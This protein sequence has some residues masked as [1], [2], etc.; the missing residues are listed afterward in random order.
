MGDHLI[1]GVEG[2]ISPA[3][4]EIFLGFIKPGVDDAAL[5]GGVFVVSV[6]ELGA[7]RSPLWG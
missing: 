1:G 7:I 2:A 3:F 6:G 5:L 4:F